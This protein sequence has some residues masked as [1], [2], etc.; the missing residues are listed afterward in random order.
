MKPYPSLCCWPCAESALRAAGDPHPVPE[1]GTPTHR[2]T[3]G[4]CGQEAQVADPADFGS[5]RFAG[6]GHPITALPEAEDFE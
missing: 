6:F 2:L 4:V 3:C 5:P 1:P